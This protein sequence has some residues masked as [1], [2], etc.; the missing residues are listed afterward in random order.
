M[1]KIRVKILM[2][3]ANEIPSYNK[4]S[5]A[6][7]DIRADFSK[8]ES[9]DDL[10]GNGRYLFF[11]EENTI[12]LLPG[13]RVLI[14]TNIHVNIPDGYEIQIRPRSGLAL[15][16]GITI[17]NTPGTIDS[18]FL[19]P[20]GIV[21]LNT[22]FENNF[23]INHADRIAQGVLNSIVRCDWVKVETID[24]L[25]DTERGQTGFGDSGVK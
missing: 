20:I 3:G 4:K 6:G 1:D 5:D 15:K 13:G 2:N 10:I 18:G 22:D 23:I 7:F 11:K 8:V 14:P 25:G 16:Y 9:R 17:V 19:G 12:S 24:E 21:L